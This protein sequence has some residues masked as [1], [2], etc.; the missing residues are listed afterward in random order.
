M[1]VKQG[2]PT[3][4]TEELGR[5]I[6]KRIS[7]G[8]SLRSICKDEGTPNK[9]TVLEWI[10]D[11]NHKEFADQYAKAR[12]IQAEL[13]ADEIFDISDDSTN[14]YVERQ[15]SNGESYTV[16]D[17]E[18]IGRSRLRVDSRKWYLSK[19][20]PKKFGERSTTELTG[21]GGSALAVQFVV[22]GG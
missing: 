8:E 15:N 14:D 18:A 4:F 16:V 5:T 11:G 21:P 19:V 9:S 7:A 22:K 6:C 3:I 1:T 13:L 12:E 20:L 17:H 10:L 2:R